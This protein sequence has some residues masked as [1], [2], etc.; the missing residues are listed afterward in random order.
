VKKGASYETIG[1]LTLE[2]VTKTV[3][4]PFTVTTNGQ[5]AVFKGKFSI[6][7]KDYNV[8]RMGTP[9]VVEINLKVPATNNT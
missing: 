9:E 3:V 1:K 6:A 5:D 7:T 2:G 4:L 8:T